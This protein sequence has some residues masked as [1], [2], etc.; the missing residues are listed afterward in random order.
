M[1]YRRIRLVAGMRCGLGVCRALERIT[2][3]QP[4]IYMMQ[5]FLEVIQ[6]EAPTSAVKVKKLQELNEDAQSALDC[7][8]EAEALHNTRAFSCRL[9]AMRS[10]GAGLDMYKVMQGKYQLCPQV[11]EL[12]AFMHEHLKN[13]DAIAKAQRGHAVGGKCY[14][15]CEPDFRLPRDISRHRFEAKVPESFQDREIHIETDPYVLGHVVR[16]VRYWFVR[17]NLDVARAQFLSNSRKHCSSGSIQLIFNGTSSNNLVFKVHDTGCGVGGSPPTAA[18]SSLAQVP[19]ELRSSLFA[20]EV[21]TGV[22]T[23]PRLG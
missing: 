7:L 3:S 4:A 9:R 1:F 6:E 13:E 2:R 17:L 10:D 18:T 19:T 22:S 16:N 14:V 11:F 12:R 15:S 21:A 20:T 8:R 23:Q 5:T